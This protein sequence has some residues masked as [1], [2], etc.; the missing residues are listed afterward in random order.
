[1]QIVIRTKCAC[2]P[3]SQM[4]L[5]SLNLSIQPWWNQ[6]FGQLG[7]EGTCH[8]HSADPKINQWSLL[9]VC[10]SC[11]NNCKF[12]IMYQLFS[13]HNNCPLRENTNS[14]VPHV[15]YVAVPF[16]ERK[17]IEVLR[18]LYMTCLYPGEGDSFPMPQ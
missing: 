1:M 18:S 10:A 9:I 11:S 17:S 4:H 14:S 7:W 15:V 3:Q 13:K 16:S 8:S 5:T 2:L 12:K 6:P